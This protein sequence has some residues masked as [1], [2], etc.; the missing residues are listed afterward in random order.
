MTHAHRIHFG[1]RV[2]EEF[3]SDLG[4]YRK[5]YPHNDFLGEVRKTEDGQ[6]L[7]LVPCEYD[8]E[9]DT[10][11]KDLGTFKHLFEAQG[12]VSRATIMSDYIL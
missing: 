4:L 10:D 12:A 5:N 3:G 2:W 7:A 11:L 8:A 1:E 9:R 6:Y